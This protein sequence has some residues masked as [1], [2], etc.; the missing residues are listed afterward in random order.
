MK[1]PWLAGVLNF[2]LIGLGTL[3][4]GKRK[5]LGLILTL[6]ALSLTYVEQ[7]IKALDASLYWQMFATVFVMNVFFA[8]DG[9][10][11]AKEANENVPRVPGQG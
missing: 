9:A 3:Y 1:K 10:R 11:E 2:F 8:M 6:G 5:G 4:V 7:S